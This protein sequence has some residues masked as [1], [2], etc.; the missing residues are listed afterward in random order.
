MNQAPETGEAKLLR[1]RLRGI[2]DS[3]GL[4]LIAI[5][6]TLILMGMFSGKPWGDTVILVAF[7]VVFFLTCRPPPRRHGPSGGSPR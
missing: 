1:P 6:A 4:V 2:E 3:Y 7:L 5:M